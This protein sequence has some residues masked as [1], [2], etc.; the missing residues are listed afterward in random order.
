[1]AKANSGEHFRRFSG[2][3]VCSNVALLIVRVLIFLDDCPNLTR[4]SE[5][6]NSTNIVIRQP[7]N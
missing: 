1:M 4:Y 2:L 5:V 6:L 3:S 7:N